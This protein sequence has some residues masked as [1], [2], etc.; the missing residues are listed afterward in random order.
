MNKLEN[1]ATPQVSV[2]VGRPGY[3][4][5][6]RTLDL[7]GGALGGLLLLPLGLFIAMLIKL[8]S[9]GPVLFSQ[10]RI[11]QGGR[12]FRFYKFRT[13]R[14]G[15]DPEVHRRYVQSLIRAELAEKA[16]A[17][18]TPHA[19]YKLVKDARVTRVGRL[20]RRSSLDELPQVIN[21]LKGEMSLV[22]PRP[23]LPYEVEAY[24]DWHK[25][26]LAVRPG[27]TGLWQV[28]GRSRVPFDEMVRMDLEYIERQSLRLDLAILVQT[29]PAIV[30]GK[31]A[32]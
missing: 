17:N 30:S 11:G 4:L 32:A 15:A 25:Q 19:P 23:P 2:R 16:E 13:M 5:A 8:D 7:L 28:R 22:G 21:V 24:E 14:V 26:R 6:K 9:P 1:V 10:V 20:L 29:V 12:P 18:G 27:L 31:G 3:R